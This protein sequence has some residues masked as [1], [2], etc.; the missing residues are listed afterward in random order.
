LDG[1]EAKL[2]CCAATAPAGRPAAL[3]R[4]LAHHRYG[5]GIKSSAWLAQGGMEGLSQVPAPA[6]GDHDLH[7]PGAATA[8][9]RPT[10]GSASQESDF[11][12]SNDGQRLPNDDG[13]V[14]EVSV[15]SPPTT[16]PRP[17]GSYQRPPQTFRDFES[18]WWTTAHRQHAGGDG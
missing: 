11:C 1:V 9:P 8:E 4:Y 16:W 18:S 2:R 3:R 10:G 7:P 14:S 12:Q 17:A 6:A 15:V 13:R 5:C